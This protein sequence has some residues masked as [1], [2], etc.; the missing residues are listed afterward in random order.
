PLAVVT[1]EGEKIAALR[2]RELD[3]A[4]AEEK[5]RIEL[6]QVPDVEVA[7]AVGRD[8]GA[9]GK[10]NRL[11]RDQL[12]IGP[13]DGVE[14]A[15][16]AAEPLDGRDGV[17]NRAVVVTVADVGPGQHA[18]SDLWCTGLRRD[19]HRDRERACDGECA[20]HAAS[21]AR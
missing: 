8:A 10:G 14:R 19:G 3:L 20:L 6:V 16:F 9:C 4:D 5:D 21:A 17:W 2:R 1:H 12:R 13:D 18:L 11:P 15:R 7:A